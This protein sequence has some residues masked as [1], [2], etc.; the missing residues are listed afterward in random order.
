MRSKLPVL[1]SSMK[2]KRTLIYIP[3]IH[4]QEDM[5]DLGETLNMVALKEFGQESRGKMQDFTAKLW[6]S[7]EQ[8]IQNLNPAFQKVKLYQDGLPL[9]DREADIVR[10]LA[11]GGSRNHQ[12][13]L[14][15]MEKGAVLMGT[16]SPELLV[17]EYRAVKQMVSAAE[18]D[19]DA[20]ETASRLETISRTIL[21][22]RDRYIAR[23]INTTLASGETGILFLGMLHNLEGMLDKDIHVSYPLYKPPHMG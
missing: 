10:D 12:L 7:I 20:R 14:R 2:T 23:R 19:Q 18:D 15:L 22:E 16:E 4:T 17:R 6:K 11:H 8:V 5:G 21:K 13:L 3:V 1:N 9:C